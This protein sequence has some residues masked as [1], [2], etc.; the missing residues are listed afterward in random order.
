MILVVRSRPQL[1]R[2]L[3]EVR[4]ARPLAEVVGLAVSSPEVVPL[5]GPPEG[6]TGVIFTSPN[7]VREPGEARA[8]AQVPAWCVG[9][10]TAA[11]ARAAG[12]RVAGVGPGDAA[13]M[14][15][16]LGGQWLA[17]QHFWHLRAEN[18]G[19]AWYA[20]LAAA[21]HR[22]TGVP[23]YRSVFVPEMPEEVAHHLR[24]KNWRHSLLMSAGSAR[25]LLMLLEE[26]KIEPLGTAHA[27]SEAVAEIARPVFPRVVVAEMPTLPAVLA[28]F[29]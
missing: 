28:T 10:T 1:D 17:P 8:A 26:A 24:Q 20:E 13:G 23:V 16:W 21:G 2:T 15:A 18:A 6:V 22:V 19:T 5:P 12:W 11:A 29:G 9:D 14:A 3:V 7:G 25:H 4:A 27:L